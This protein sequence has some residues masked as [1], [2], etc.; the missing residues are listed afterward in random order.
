MIHRPFGNTGLDVSAIAF[1]A[2]PVPALLTGVDRRRQTAVVAAAL[3]VG[4]NWFD[5][6]PTYGDGAS[7]TSLGAALADLGARDV[8]IASKV[9]IE[10]AHFADLR[11]SVFDIVRASLKRLGIPRLALLQLHNAITADDGE[12]PSS[13]GVARVLS[14]GGV[15][16]ALEAIRRD[17]LCA[18]LGL[19]GIGS[20]AALREL[21]A[22]GRFAAAQVPFSI[23]QPSAG[24]AVRG[25]STDDY[26]GLLADCQ[27]CNVAAL[28]IRV[29]AG[30]AV[31]GQPPSEH[32]KRTPY[33]PL[34]AF[35]A[36]RRRAGRIAPS[37]PPDLPIAAAA[38]RFVAHHEAVTSALV[39]FST[40]EQVR[41]AAEHVAAG[42]LSDDVIR[43]I[44]AAAAEQH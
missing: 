11:R 31:T 17:G 12:R 32:T 25:P 2:G 21:F 38:L 41:Q 15:L 44:I 16:D 3:D 36:D 30:G 18:H 43:A 13:L 42:P 40:V 37:L 34:A 27:R 8:H 10:P 5:T 1:G 19:T 29:F 35:E 6:A 14:P 39:G 22:T 9:R 33:F 24:Y 7:E 20:P 26:D 23:V 28:A 4:V